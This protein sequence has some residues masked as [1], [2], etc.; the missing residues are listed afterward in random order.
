M[1]EAEVPDGVFEKP[2]TALTEAPVVSYGF[3][4]ETWGLYFPAVYGLLLSNLKLEYLL[5][6]LLPA[7]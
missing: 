2:P 1:L 3:L 5:S 4:T 6:F 7:G